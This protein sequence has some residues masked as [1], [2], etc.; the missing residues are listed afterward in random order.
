[1]KSFKGTKMNRNFDDSNEKS[2]NKLRNVPNL[3]NLSKDYSF[4]NFKN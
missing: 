4:S 2:F 3:N 1:M